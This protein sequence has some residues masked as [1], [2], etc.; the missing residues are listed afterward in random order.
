MQL[1]VSVNPVVHI[2]STDNTLIHEVTA[3]ET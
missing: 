2:R 3:D 1:A